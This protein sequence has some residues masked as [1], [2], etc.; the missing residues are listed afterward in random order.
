[1]EK[2]TEIKGK[3]WRREREERGRRQ[4]A[5]ALQV[6]HGDQ[7]TGVHC[8]NNMLHSPSNN[9]HGKKG[10]HPKCLRLCVTHVQDTRAKEEAA[11]IEENEK[12][13]VDARN[14]QFIKNKYAFSIFKTFLDLYIAETRERHHQKTDLRNKNLS[15]AGNWKLVLIRQIFAGGRPEEAFFSKLDSNLRKNTAFVKKL[16]TITEAQRDSLMKDMSGLNLTKYISEAA[17]AIVEAKLKMSDVQTAVLVCSALHQRYAEFSTQLLENWVKAL[18]LKK[19][20][21]V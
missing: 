3:S 2:K 5:K 8:N 13:S 18:P 10:H 17:A 14:K 6:E 1:S 9:G 19:D 21:K 4:Q 15:A 7:K 11:S 20:D 12:V 16:K